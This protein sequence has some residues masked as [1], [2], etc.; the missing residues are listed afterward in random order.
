M[1][2]FALFS[3]SDALVQ[4]SGRAR[5]FRAGK[6]LV[7]GMLGRCTRAWR[8]PHQA[9]HDGGDDDEAM[10]KDSACAGLERALGGAA[11]PVSLQD[12]EPPNAAEVRSSR[13]Q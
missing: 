6:T 7:L 1:V 4:V 2:K 5:A 3:K 9:T 12:S 8:L 13:C 10:N 11:A